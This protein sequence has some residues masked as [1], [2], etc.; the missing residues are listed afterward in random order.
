MMPLI[1]RMLLLLGVSSLLLVLVA[2]GL[3]VDGW[4]S[5]GKTPAHER[6]AAME[7]SPQW[8]EGVFVNP[9]PIRNDLAASLTAW[10]EMSPF[11]E[12]MTEVPV[13]PGDRTRF[14]KP[15]ASGLRITWLGHSTVICE[16]DGIT[17][18]TDPVFGGRASPFTWAGPSAWYEPPIP[19]SELP[20]LDVVLLSHDHYDHLQIETIQ[21]LAKT[22]TLF[23]APLGVGE[24][25]EYWGVR[26]DR[27]RNVDWWDRV[28]VGGVEIVATPSRHASGRQLLDQNRTLW[29][30][31]ALL[32]PDHRVF[33]SGDT[34]LFPGLEEIGE[35][36]GPF[37]VAMLE[38]GAYHRAWP[39]WH[40]GPENAL[41]AHEMV[42][43]R[44][45]L[46]IHWGLWNLAMHGWTEPVERVLVEAKRRG[47]TTYIPRPGESL[48][49]AALPEWVQWWPDLPWAGVDEHPI[50]ATGVPAERTFMR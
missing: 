44:L 12:P 31:Y 17:V 37:D 24:H 18:L 49:P 41:R 3:V 40:L 34:G 50:Q 20:E 7:A 19:L 23:V 39:D 11:A 35:R 46:P 45:F 14:A 16:I 48:E 22:D 30:G 10:T 28:T 15:P 25:L 8:S 2:V 27:I 9:Q 1:R 47:V 13:V 6:Q 42:R 36:L 43:G 38:V 32:G 33:F 21:A 29:A 4:V 5:F 26:A